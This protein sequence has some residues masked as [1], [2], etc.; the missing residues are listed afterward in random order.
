VVLLFYNLDDEQSLKEQVYLL[1][2]LKRH[3]SM[4]HAGRYLFNVSKL[5]APIFNANSMK[6]ITP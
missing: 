1:E 3:V 6:A 5:I 4:L 2:I